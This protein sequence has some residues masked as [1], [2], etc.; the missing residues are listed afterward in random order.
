MVKAP[1][2]QIDLFS[3]ILDY[4]EMGAQPSEGND[5]RP[6][7]EGSDDGTHRVAI[8]EWSSPRVPRFMVFD[9]RWKLLYGNVSDNQSLDAL[10]DLQS[11][12]L[13]MN[14][15]I[16]HNPERENNTGEKSSG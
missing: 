13:E 4:C 2:A 16:G 7:I 9:G 15:L 5:L 14:N 11:D 1:V 6:L 8:S 3:T 12:P 10:Y